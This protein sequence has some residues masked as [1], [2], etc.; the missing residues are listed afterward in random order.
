MVATPPSQNGK[1]LLR[2]NDCSMHTKLSEVKMM[3]FWDSTF[4]NEKSNSEKVC[5]LAYTS[6]NS[7]RMGRGVLSKPSLEVQIRQPRSC[8]IWWPLIYSD[9]MIYRTLYVITRTL[10][11]SWKSTSKENAK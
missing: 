3:S 4:Q 1:D 2:Q 9:I 11:W 5:F 10:K 6:L 7:R 8:L